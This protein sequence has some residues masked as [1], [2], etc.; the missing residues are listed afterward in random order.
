[1]SLSATTLADILRLRREIHRHP[2]RSGCEEKTARR[3]ESFIKAQSPDDLLTGLGGFGIAAVF[4]SGKVGPSVLLRAELDAVPI[5]EAGGR[6]YG[7]TVPSISHACGHDGHMAILCALAARLARC[8]P[9]KGRVVLLFQPAEETGTGAAKVMSDPRFRAIAPDH[10]FALHNLPGFPEG[11]VVIRAGQFCPASMGIVV[12]LQGKAAHAAQPET[13]RSPALPM[14]RIVEGLTTVGRNPDAPGALPPA[15]VVHARLGEPGAFGMSPG[16]AVVMATLRSETDRGLSDM[17]NR[18]IG[19]AESAA[20]QA[21][22]ALEIERRDPFPATVN[23]E[24]ETAV[25]AAAAAAG[26]LP[27]HWLAHPLPWSEDFGRFTGRFGGALFG[28]G[29]GRAMADLHHP[30]YDFPDS[31]IPRGCALFQSILDQLSD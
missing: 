17:V 21:D 30:D 11:V 31:L 18:G 23:T 25:V 12:R 1:M 27:I 4:D 13:G 9:V 5:Q 8:R 2:E 26:G 29:A 16:S 19:M 6:P 20:A 22:V 7:S 10:A 28:L 14:C 3:I 24:M 15:T